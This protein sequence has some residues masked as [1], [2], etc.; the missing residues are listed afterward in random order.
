MAKSSSF[1]GLR[2]GSTKSLTFQVLDGKQ[3]TKDRV[4]EVRNPKTEKQQIQRVIMLTALSAYSKMMSIVDHS[5]EGV[6][7]G[8]KTQQ[9]FMSENLRA[10]RTRLAQAGNQYANKKAFVPIGQSFLAPNYYV[11]SKGSLPAIPCR[12]GAGLQFKGG[13]TYAEV[14][15]NLKAQP[16]D[17]LTVCVIT[18]D[19][20]YTQN[21]FHFCRIILQP[22]DENGNNLPLTEYFVASDG[23][24][25]KP[26][27]RNELTEGFSFDLYP[28]DWYGVTFGF[29]ST[30]AGCAILSREENRKWLRSTQ[31][32]VVADNHP[33]FTLQEAIDSSVLDI[34]VESN[35]F[36]NNASD[37]ENPAPAVVAGA[38]YGDAVIA[39][40]ATL[41]GANTITIEGT[42]MNLSN[43]VLLADGVK[44][45]PATS[46]AT[47]RTYIVS[48]N[49]KFLLMANDQ[50]VLRFEVAGI[51][52]PTNITS[53]MW[54]TETF[55]DIPHTDRD[56]HQSGGSMA[57]EING[58]SL[59]DATVT[60][61]N[62][63]FVVSNLNKTAT[64]ITGQIAFNTEGSGTLLVNGNVVISFTSSANPYE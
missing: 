1:F 48:H 60:S 31:T 23:S 12:M 43:V 54:G 35:R 40:G 30:I 47:S 8:G 59:A 3:I 45:N 55:T 26:N 28:E 38:K 13:E 5:Y 39:Q 49:A 25:N 4:L 29:E 62:P 19:T 56:Q 32:M 16:G 14:I 21:V 2:R 24:I 22:Q 6:S 63:M 7:Y 15:A 10:V 44:W 46:S 33:G 58:T 57:F 18:G 37:L 50:V 42:N 20:D 64:K 27:K 36:L 61:S 51:V 11:M 41:E 52:P 9:A 53:V 17:Q 34:D